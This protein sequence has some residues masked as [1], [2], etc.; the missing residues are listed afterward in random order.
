MAVDASSPRLSQAARC[1]GVRSHEVSLLRGA[2]FARALFVT[3][4]LSFAAGKA[5]APA[6]RDAIHGPQ[7]GLGAPAERSGEGRARA[8]YN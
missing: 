8:A 3:S 7:E 4:G 6:P 2:A 1:E 5:G